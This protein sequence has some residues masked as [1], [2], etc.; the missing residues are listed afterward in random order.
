MLP[1]AC[2]HCYAYLMLM[3][4][5]HHHTGRTAWMHML[6][7]MHNHTINQLYCCASICQ[8]LQQDCPCGCLEGIAA[9]PVLYTWKAVAVDLFSSRWYQ[10]LWQSSGN[11]C[12][13]WGALYEQQKMHATCRCMVQMSSARGLHKARRSFT[14]PTASRLVSTMFCKQTA[15][16]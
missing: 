4:I 15:A 6:T 2:S 12:M 7:S 11:V 9:A 5:C 8:N 10:A 14:C 1:Y 3:S 13:V 16:A